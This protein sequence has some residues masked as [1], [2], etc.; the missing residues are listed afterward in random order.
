MLISDERLKLE[1]SMNSSSTSGKIQVIGNAGWVELKNVGGCTGQGTY[2]D[3]YIIKEVIIDTDR[4]SKCISISNSDVYFKIINTTLLNSNIGIQLSNVS[5]S[6][7]INNTISR[8]FKGIELTHC[9]N[10]AVLMNTFDLDY[11]GVDIFYSDNITV[12]KNTVKNARDGIRLSESSN[13]TIF[14][15]YMSYCGLLISGSL[16]SLLSLSIDSS[17]LVNGKP[18]SYHIN[19]SNLELKNISNAGQVMLINCNNSILSNILV[20]GASNGIFLAYCHNSTLL[21][22]KVESN[23]FGIGLNYCS[24]SNISLN[25]VGGNYYGIKL[26]QCSN[27][28]ISTNSLSMDSTSISL[29]QSCENNFIF[30]NT[31]RLSGIGIGIYGSNHNLL[32]NNNMNSS[33]FGNTGINLQFSDENVISGNEIKEYECGIMLIWSKYNNISLNSLIGNG[34]CFY[35]DDGCVGNIF[36]N[37]FCPHTNNTIIMGYDLIFILGILSVGSTIIILKYRKKMVLKYKISVD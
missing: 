33:L 2:S 14:E 34:R 10:V 35:E 11:F 16:D 6:M 4:S 8:N 29:Y 13:S 25:E 32:L 9:H 30:N 31:I 24:M 17:N 1:E 7:L 36:D 15:N 20:S 21:R 18:L 22:N 37:N 26:Y 23:S 28:T 12:L 19:E 27:N 3:P 5:N